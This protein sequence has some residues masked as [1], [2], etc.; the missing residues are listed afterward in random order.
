L[1]A[2]LNELDPQVDVN[3]PDVRIDTSVLHRYV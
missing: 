2:R 1:T 3:D